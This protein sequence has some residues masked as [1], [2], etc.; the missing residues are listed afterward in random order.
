M[1][2]CDLG[3]LMAD[4]YMKDSLAGCRRQIPTGA[5]SKTHCE[6]CGEP[7]PEARR[8]AMPGCTRCVECA[9]EFERS[10]L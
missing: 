2:E 8:K 7:I 1:D 5:V 9:S 3:S 4:K 6:D 10:I